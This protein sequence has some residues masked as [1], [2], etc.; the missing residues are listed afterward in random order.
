MN[1]P[2]LLSILFLMSITACY[3]DKGNYDYH[4]INEI[5]ISNID[6]EYT[7][8]KWQNLSIKPELHFSIEETEQIAYRWE[9]DGKVVSEERNLSYDVALNVADEAYKC[10]F[11]A[12]HL[13][14]SSRYYY[15]FS[16]R[17][18]TPYDKGLLV[19]SEQNDKA[20]LSFHAENE[21][22]KNFDKWVYYKENGEYL[23]G[24]PLSLEQPDYEYN[25]EIFIT[26]SRGSYRLDKNI[27]KLLK[28]YN[29]ETMLIKQPEFNIKSCSFMD[30]TAY[31]PWGCVIDANGVPYIF[32]D[33]NDYWASP[34]PNPIPTYSDPNV[35]INYNLDEQFILTVTGY[36]STGRFLGYDNLEGRFLYFQKQS[37]P[38]PE[39]FNRV[40][41]RT[42]IIG[43]PALAIGMFSYEEYASFFYDPKTNIAKVVPSHDATFSGMTEK[44]VITLE[45]HEFTPQT[46]LKFCDATE[47]AIF[48]SGSVIRQ[49]RMR[50]VTAGSSILSDKLPTNAEIT[51]LKLSVD[52]KRLYVGVFNDNNNEFKG[53]LYLLDAVTGGIIDCYPAVGGK[54]IDVIEKF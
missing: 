7:R 8:E 14:D 49:I 17:V 19:L 31:E 20:M 34:S 6:E 12:I 27:L 1:K 21:S 46:I 50:N 48:S 13:E 22:D 51:C 24:S 54:I 44:D 53:D 2:Y 42:P 40:T 29:G 9:L 35:L 41:V 52:R 39:Q 45:K 32:R 43:L 33:R 10:R 38:D 36:G 11:T 37:S 23:E 30:I 4:T 16:L 5:S 18:V 15:D 28:L 25:S 26:T 47:R 3:E